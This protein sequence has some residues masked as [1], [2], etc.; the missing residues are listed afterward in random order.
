MRTLQA[1]TERLASLCERHHPARHSYRTSKT[2]DR[3]WFR[4]TYGIGGSDAFH[5][6]AYDLA[7][8]E[9]VY[10]RERKPTSDIYTPCISECLSLTR[11][12]TQSE[13]GP[14][15]DEYPSSWETYCPESSP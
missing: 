3:I 12:A 14:R 6:W 1:E 4:R 13:Y 15:P 11:R 9:L 8:G 2:G 10:Y 7:S 5:L